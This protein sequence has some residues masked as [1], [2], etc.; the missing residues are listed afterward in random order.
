MD[1]FCKI[2][3]TMA[4]VSCFLLLFAMA[5]TFNENRAFLVII[6]KEFIQRSWFQYPILK[7]FLNK[8]EAHKRTHDLSRKRNCIEQLGSLV[9]S[10]EFNTIICMT[11]FISAHANW[12]ALWAKNWRV[13]NR[14]Q[15]LN[16]LFWSETI[17][18][19][20]KKWSSLHHCM[21]RN[22][23]LALDADAYIPA[24]CSR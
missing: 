16:Y 12:P 15:G 21:T 3:T 5:D 18:Q 11:S 9:S 22:K 10:Y 23:Q 6:P 19:V 2:A 14:K 13:W 8:K 20:N 1:F 17:S 7:N 24:N 4:H